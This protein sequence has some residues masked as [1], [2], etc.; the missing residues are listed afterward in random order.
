MLEREDF[1]GLRF[2][3]IGSGSGLFSL[4]AR[5]LG[6]T[7]HSF[8]YDPQSVACTRELKRRYRDNDEGWTIEQAS[9]LDSGYLATLGAFDIVYSWGVLHHTGHM[10]RALELATVP[11]AE[12]GR[13]FIA[14]YNDQG[15]IS[16]YWGG[17]KRI[18]NSGRLGRGSMIALHA[19]Y[20]LGARWAYRLLRRRGAIERGMTYWYDMLDWLGGYP[21]EIASP[22][23]VAHFFRQRG[24]TVLK[25][26]LCGRRHG[27]NEFILG[28]TR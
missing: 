17:V 16:R 15:L 26:R 28:R 24:L 7:V 9:A 21:F 12:D 2:L 19:P 14:I 1:T 13:L 25:S 4:A 27:C 5:R 22:D 18:Y 20:L 11:L 8:D 10:W 23:A 6:A 3:D